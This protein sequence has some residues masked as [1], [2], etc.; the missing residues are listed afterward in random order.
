MRS[1]AGVPTPTPE[2]MDLLATARFEELARKLKLWGAKPKETLVSFAIG[3]RPRIF[4]SCHRSY[5]EKPPA[6]RLAEPMFC[7]DP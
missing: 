7:K 5:T 2:L 4:P 6:R 1:R 3:S